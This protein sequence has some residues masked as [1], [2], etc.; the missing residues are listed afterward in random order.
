M[1]R[2]QEE[3]PFIGK[4]GDG[5]LGWPEAAPF[6]AI[7]VTCA[8]D[9]VPPILIRQLREGGRLVISVGDAGC[10]QQLYTLE[11]IDGMIQQR[12][13]APVRFVPMVHSSQ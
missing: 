10:T 6:D 11:K 2:R 7:I 8:P 12:T 3:D 4:V 5:Y 13:V 1:W 9:N